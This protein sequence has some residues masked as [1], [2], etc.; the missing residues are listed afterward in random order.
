V[1]SISCGVYWGVGSVREDEAHRI[2]LF[3]VV[4]EGTSV[5]VQ[6]NVPGRSVQIVHVKSV[7]YFVEQPF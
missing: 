4:V 5:Q 2:F 3:C 1:M 6:T 7:S